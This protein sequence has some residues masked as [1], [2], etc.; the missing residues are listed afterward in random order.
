MH[1]QPS[2]HP[3]GQPALPN[4]PLDAARPAAIPTA[5]P[6]PARRTGLVIGIVTAVLVIAALAAVA[7]LAAYALG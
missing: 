2:T 3:S 7:A 6:A 5:P 4:Y 1:P